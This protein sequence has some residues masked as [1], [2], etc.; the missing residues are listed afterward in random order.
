VPLGAGLLLSIGTAQWILLRH[1][2]SRGGRWITVTAG[3]AVF[4]AFTMPLWR[5]GQPL[6]L[7]VVIGVAGGTLMAATMAAITGREVRRMVARAV[8]GAGRA[9][10]AVGATVAA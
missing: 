10:P 2:V 7:T 8:P 6:A 9:G 4:L 3:L 1:L 5:P